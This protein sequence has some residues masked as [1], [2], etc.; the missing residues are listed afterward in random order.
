MKTNFK[1]KAGYRLRI[2]GL[3]TVLAVSNLFSQS[4]RSGNFWQEGDVILEIVGQGRVPSP[5]S[6]IQFGYLSSIAGLDG[7]FTA[8]DPSAQNE[9]TALFTFFNDS[10]TLRSVVNGGLAIINRE[11]TMTI[12]YDPI[13]NGDFSDP[14]SFSDGIPVQISSWRHQV[15]L[16]LGT[17]RLSVFSRIGSLLSRP[18]ISVAGKS[19]LEN[20]GTGSECTSRDSSPALASSSSPATRSW[21]GRN[22]EKTGRCFHAI[23]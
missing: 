10:T 9:G 14:T 13:P 4:V 17:G 2:A 8:D 16:D 1:G 19:G 23:R 22:R 7:I 12:Y 18:L 15:I 5:A 11:G 20:L 3:L 21:Q 6:A